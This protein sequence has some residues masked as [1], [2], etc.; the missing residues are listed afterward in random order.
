[1]QIMEHGIGVNEVGHRFICF[2]HTCTYANTGILYR[3]NISVNRNNS[4]EDIG[5]G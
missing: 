2:K 5:P 1:M 3:N 4:K